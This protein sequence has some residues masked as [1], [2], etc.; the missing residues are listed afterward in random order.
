[1]YLFLLCAVLIQEDKIV[2]GGE[3]INL[4]C[5]VESD[6]ENVQTHLNIAGIEPQSQIS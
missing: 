5:L 4:W 3:G 6:W 2:G 1:M